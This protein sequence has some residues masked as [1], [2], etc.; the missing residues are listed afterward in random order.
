MTVI[1]TA[2]LHPSLRPHT[3]S[4]LCVPWFFFSLASGLHSR[5]KEFKS[6]LNIFVPKIGERRR[7]SLHP[8]RIELLAVSELNTAGTCL[9]S[10]P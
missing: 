10:M 9:E 5:C 1:P 3:S 2:L 7:I 6:V 8:N 4:Y